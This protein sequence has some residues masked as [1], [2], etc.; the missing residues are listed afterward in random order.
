MDDKEHYDRGM[1]MRRKTMGAAHVD[2]ALANTTP[3]NAEFQELLTHY[4][5]GVWTRPHFD[6]RTRR[7]LVIG[8]LIA[9]G[10]WEELRAHV[11][12]AVV[13]GGFTAD[14]IKE[15]IL[16]QTI[17]CGAPAGNRAFKETGEV[18]AELQKN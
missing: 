3:F 4:L 18:L 6:V 11:R 7:V 9:L 14:D 10:H 1:A 13:E 8:T 17:Y 16:Q 15:I 12:A 2:R 5:W